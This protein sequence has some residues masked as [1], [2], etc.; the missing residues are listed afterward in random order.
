MTFHIAVD[1][2]KE[3]INIELGIVRIE[4]VEVVT[5]DLFTGIDLG[6]RSDADLDSGLCDSDGCLCPAAFLVGIIAVVLN[7]NYIAVAG[8]DLGVGDIVVSGIKLGN[9]GLELNGKISGSRSFGEVGLF[10]VDNAC[11][12][13]FFQQPRPYC[14]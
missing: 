2:D 8:I 12:D 1:A 6:D 10:I 5:V 11:Y 13:S 7:T 3:N 14:R 4:C 9:S